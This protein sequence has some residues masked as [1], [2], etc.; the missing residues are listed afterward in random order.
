MF[1]ANGNLP[2]GFH[3]WSLDEIKEK[4]VDRFSPS[5]NRNGLFTGY[6]HLRT[7]M[8]SMSLEFEQWLDGSFCTQKENPG[9][10]DMLSLIPIDKLQKL[11]PAEQA[12]LMSCVDGPGSKPKYCCDS[13]YLPTDV[14]T[15]DPQYEYYRQLY[16]YWY[17]EF[18]IDRMNRPKGIVRNYSH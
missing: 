17:G 2:P 8:L 9:D 13:Y 16:K 14:P 4:L 6:L 5:S 1:D 3:D 18:G 15:S 10:I 7:D 11:N 12:F